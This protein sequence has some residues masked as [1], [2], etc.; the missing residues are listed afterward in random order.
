M[1]PRA[2]NGETRTTTT[3]TTTTRRLVATGEE[4]EEEEEEERTVKGRW[5]CR[6][7]RGG[8]RSHRR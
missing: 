6:G 4:E 7:R 2:R 3:A 1:I 5:T 8:R